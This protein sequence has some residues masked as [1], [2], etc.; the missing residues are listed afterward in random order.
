MLVGLVLDM[1]HYAFGG[2]D[3][4][5]ALKEFSDRIWHVHFK[6]FMADDMGTI[7]RIYDLAGHPLT[8]EVEKAM[9]DYIAAN[10]R[11]KHGQVLYDMEADFGISLDSLYQRFSNYTN[12]FKVALERK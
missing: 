7:A 8:P 11:G 6:D 2:G 10:P 4:L 1:G 5:K 12:H 3:P 9:T